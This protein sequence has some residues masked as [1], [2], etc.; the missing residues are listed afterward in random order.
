MLEKLMLEQSVTEALRTCYDPEIP[1][2]I[3]DLGLVYDVDIDDAGRVE[4]RMTLTAPGCPVAGS[5]PGQIEEKIAAVDGVTGARVELV[6]D[7]P[8][9]PSRMSESARLELGMM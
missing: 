8:W 5:L 2:N 3:V 4:V 6:W 7:P 9:D 1:V